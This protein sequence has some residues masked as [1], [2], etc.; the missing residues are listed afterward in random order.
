VLLAVDGTDP[1]GMTPEQ[2]EQIGRALL[3]SAAAVRAES[4]GSRRASVSTAWPPAECPP[5]CSF[6]SRP[7]GHASN[8][9][10]VMHPVDRHHSWLSETEQESDVYLS[11][12]TMDMV[13]PATDQRLIPQRLTLGME[14]HYRHVEPTISITHQNRGWRRKPDAFIGRTVRE[15]NLTPAE[16]RQ[17]GQRLVALADMADGAA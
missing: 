15:V 7:G 8:G 13:N 1:T 5:W 16:A 11:L 10:E 9:T 14:Q 17:L 2:A 3:D 12:H 6:A 4:A